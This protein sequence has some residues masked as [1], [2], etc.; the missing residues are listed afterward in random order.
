MT[1]PDLAS[2]NQ[3]LPASAPSAAFRSAKLWSS[4]GGL[5]PGAGVLKL[6]G[7]RVMGSQGYRVIRRVIGFRVIG[8]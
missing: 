6:Q 7:Y 2:D 3:G 4:R 8:S 5:A 1:F